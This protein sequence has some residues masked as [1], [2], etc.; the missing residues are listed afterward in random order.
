LADVALGLDAIFVVVGGLSCTVHFVVLPISIVLVILTLLDTWP[1][2]SV[3][4]EKS[5]E[6]AAHTGA[7][8]GSFF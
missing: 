4:L 7:A 8:R 3:S 2:G 5:S 6:V 1:A